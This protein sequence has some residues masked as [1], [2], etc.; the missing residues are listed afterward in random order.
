MANSCAGTELEIV[1]GLADSLQEHLP[2]V[3]EAVYHSLYAALSRGTNLPSYLYRNYLKLDERVN[4]KKNV[5]AYVHVACKDCS[6]FALRRPEVVDFL[7]S[8]R[9]V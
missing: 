1:R 4:H 2:T 5:E 6:C 9:A 8:R 3:G 7:F